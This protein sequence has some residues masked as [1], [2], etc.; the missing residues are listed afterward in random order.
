MSAD[1]EATAP[2][3]DSEGVSLPWQIYR[4]IRASII[5]GEYGPGMRLNEQRLA[6][7]LA[8]S[9]VPLRESFPLLERDGFIQQLP[10]RSAVVSSWTTQ[11]VDDL[12]DTRLSVEVEAARLATRKVAAG[13]SMAAVEASLEESE[14]L[15]ESGA[16][17]RLIAEASTRFHEL[18]VELTDNDLLISLMRPISQRMTWLFYL[19][20]RRDSKRACAEHRELF[21]AIASGNEELARSVA[22]FHIEMGR[23][24]SLETLKL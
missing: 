1:L 2:A 24:P 6:E 12:F 11:R 17:D 19:T 13:R 21:A 22:Y 4:Q 23:Q 7:S 18:V 5:S 10:R 8:V 20:S 3:A 15:I 16:D 9:R 14:Q